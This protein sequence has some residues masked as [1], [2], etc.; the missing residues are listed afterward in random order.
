MLE[1]MQYIDILII[2]NH[3]IT[4]LG[5][6]QNLPSGQ[7]YLSGSLVSCLL[8]QLLTGAATGGAGNGDSSD[9][10]L[11]ADKFDSVLSCI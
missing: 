1:N 3:A 11:S 6:S 2:K 8:V 10:R 4:A 7:D 5:Y 9:D